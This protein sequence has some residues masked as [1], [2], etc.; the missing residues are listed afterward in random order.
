[1]AIRGWFI[2]IDDFQDPTASSLSGAVRDATAMHAIFKDGLPEIDDSLLVNGDASH[3]R[4]RQCLAAAFE[5]ATEEDVVI[6]S[7]ATHGTENHR[8]VAQDTDILRLDDTAIP[9]ADVVALF[10]SSK[11]R[12]ILCIIDCCFSGEAPARVIKDTPKAR[13]IIDIA[14]IPGEGRLLITACRNDEEAF[15]HP[16][17]RHGLLTAAIMD[18]LT[19]PGAGGILAIV[20]RVIARVRTDAAAMGVSQN[21]VAS[22]Y[23]DGGFALPTLVRGDTYANAFPEYGAVRVTNV[24]ELER[25]GIPPQI[26]AAWRTSFDNHLHQLQ[27]DAINEFRVLDGHSLFVIAPTSSGKTFV[28]EIAGIRAVLERRK[29]VFLLPLRALVNEK[30]DDFNKIYGEQ[31]GLRVIRCTGDYHDDIATFVTGKFDIALLTYE[32][33]LSTA[34]T[35]EA[36]LNILGLVVLDEAQY[37]SDPGRGINVELVLTLLRAK[38]S[39]GINPQLVLLSAVVGN[40]DQF[41]AWLDIRVLRSGTRPVPL[42]FGAIDRSGAYEFID[43]GGERHIEQ[44]LNPHDIRVRRQEPSAQDVVVPLARR[45]LQTPGSSVIVFRNRRGS[46]EGAAGYLAAEMGLPPAADAIGRLPR[47]DLSNSSPP[48]RRAL[49]G[50]TAFHTSDLN[51]DERVVVEQAFRSG[52]VRVLTATSGIAAGINT[53][54]SAVIIAETQWAAPGTPEMSIGDVRNMAGRAGRY[55]Y[56]ENG[57]AIMIADSAWR[58]TRLVDQYVL[59]VPPPL[60]ST[61]G[62]DDIPTWLLRLLRQMNRIPRND[63]P[64]LL[65]NSFGGYVAALQ[66]PGFLA[67]IQGQVTNLL[68]RMQQEGLIDED[69]AGI[70]LTVLGRAC[71]A[72]SISLESCL[73]IL[74]AM[75]RINRQVAPEQLMALTQI[76]READANYIPMNRRNGSPEARWVSEA[77]HRFGQDIAGGLQQGAT[78]ANQVWARAKKALIVLAYVSGMPI[79]QIE[80]NFTSNARYYGVG[81]GDITGTSDNTRYRLRSVYELVGIAYP[82]FA[83]DPIAV[84]ELFQ[85]MELGIP[86]DIL[87]LMNAPTPLNRAACLSLRQAGIRTVEDLLRTPEVRLAEILAAPMLESLRPFLVQA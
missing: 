81:A 45:L 29:A 23:V 8:I 70:A 17:R 14:G 4:I 51:R 3:N 44:L 71:G 87:D 67:R 18:A 41:A 31:L 86:A 49:A 66:D 74:G 53:P 11:A 12:F 34:L 6:F 24:S 82:A 1:M 43:E 10:R 56:Q 40:A 21:P 77:A 55:G 50:G 30:Y 33:F 63:V 36:L 62:A 38:R 28:G 79:N 76:A 35:N 60:H 37:L 22:A 42:F 68:A 47:T 83:P 39:V 25:F 46:A 78:E 75:R 65:L 26:I 2:G 27:L 13:A 84:A 72:A 80:T 15:E 85:Q 20:E 64:A 61:F 69:M 58:R 48:L 32:M 57:R 9:L 5:E 52:A 16:S 7:F 73:L 19:D 59:G 54:A